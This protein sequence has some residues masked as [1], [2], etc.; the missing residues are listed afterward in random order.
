[1]KSGNDLGR[2]E[3]G[4]I[5]AEARGDA[6]AG[7]WS[8]VRAAQ[9]GD[10]ASFEQLYRLHEGRIRAL[11]SR[12]SGSADA[13]EEFTQEVFVRA[14][15]NLDTF[16]TPGH[17]PAWLTRVAVN[18]VM[19]E[20]RT[21]ARRG[22]PLSLDEESRPRAVTGP[23]RAG[24]RVDLDGAIAALPEKARAVLVLHDIHGFKHREIAD[25]MGSAVGTSKVLLHRARQRLRETLGL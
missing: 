8:L 5:L 24:L 11:C 4:A 2:G 1:V 22:T 18:L 25:I 6:G 14:W 17:F 20:R 19:T 9:K 7:E 21:L 13:A 3:D 23:P 15:Q 12:L 16:R 10:R